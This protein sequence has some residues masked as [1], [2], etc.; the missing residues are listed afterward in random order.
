MTELHNMYNLLLSALTLSLISLLAL[1]A[2]L[3]GVG[4]AM[5]VIGMLLIVSTITTMALAFALR[6]V[7]VRK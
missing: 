3:V 2:K 1:H 4:E 6:L 5:L 7:P